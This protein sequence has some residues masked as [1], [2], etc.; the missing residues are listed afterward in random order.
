M[1]FF[2]IKNR[3]LKYLMRT[4]AYI[5]TIFGVGYF[6]LRRIQKYKSYEHHPFDIE[7]SY[8]TSVYFLWSKYEQIKKE[9]K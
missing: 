8:K 6:K 5:S 4:S 9:T 7:E 1:N 3:F 2:K